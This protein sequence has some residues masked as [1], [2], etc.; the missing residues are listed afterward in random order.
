MLQVLVRSLR[1]MDRSFGSFEVALK[2]KL[3]CRYPSVPLVALTATATPLVQQDVV[4]QLCLRNCVV[5]RSSFNRPN[6]RC[7]PPS[8]PVSRSVLLFPTCKKQLGSPCSNTGSCSVFPF[9]VLPETI[10][11]PCSNTGSCSVFLFSVLPKTKLQVLTL[12]GCQSL[13]KS[14]VLWSNGNMIKMHAGSI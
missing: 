5:F 3:W 2:G 7:S 10:G 4:Q 12:Q 6:L 1:R 9:S 11:S 14:E 13:T 8:N